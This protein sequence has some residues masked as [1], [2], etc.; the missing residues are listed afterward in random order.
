MFRLPGT[1]AGTTSHQ[2]HWPRRDIRVF[3]SPPNTPPAKMRRIMSAWTTGHGNPCRSRSRCRGVLGPT[4]VRRATP[5]HCLSPHLARR[6]ITPEPIIDR[7][8]TNIILVDFE[9]VQPKDLASLR[10]R[11]FK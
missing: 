5:L 1:P 7:L 11:P 10:G 6:T 2:I 8:K 4:P 3:E 9:N